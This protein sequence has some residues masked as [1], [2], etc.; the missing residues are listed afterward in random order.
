MKRRFSHGNVI[1]GGI[2]YD[3]DPYDEW[4]ETMNKLKAN[5]ACIEGAE[6]RYAQEGE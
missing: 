2:V 4:M 1:G 6:E 3:S 5:M